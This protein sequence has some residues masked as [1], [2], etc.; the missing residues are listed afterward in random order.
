[1]T[2][3]KDPDI[4][5]AE[6]EAKGFKRKKSER[7]MTA[8]TQHICRHGFLTRVITHRLF[9][10]L[11]LLF[12]SPMG[13]KSLLFQWE[14]PQHHVEFFIARANEIFQMKQSFIHSFIFTTACISSF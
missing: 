9:C 11:V 8:V 3:G 5:R 14:Q 1:M 2:T 4:Q 6:S 13:R 12:Q 10:I 7:K